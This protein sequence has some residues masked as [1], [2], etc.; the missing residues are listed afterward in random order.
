[1]LYKLETFMQ[2]KYNFHQSKNSALDKS[3]DS[4]PLDNTVPI[5]DYTYK[6]FMLA[7]EEFISFQYQNLYKLA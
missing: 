5:N 1:M 6:E 2:D 7:R 4:E 3:N